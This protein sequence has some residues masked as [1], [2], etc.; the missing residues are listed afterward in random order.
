MRTFDFSACENGGVKT[1][2]ELIAE[3]QSLGRWEAIRWPTPSGMGVASYRDLHGRIGACAGYLDEEG[4]KKGD[5]A[6]I[7]AENSLEWV[8]FFW[9]CVAR[10]IHVV[11]ADFRFSP[12]LVARI[13]AD[14]G[15]RLTLDT[16]ALQALAQRKPAHD[17][18]ITSVEPDDIVE[19]VYTSG[20]TGDPKG[21][22]HRHRTICANLEPFR[23]EI[24]KYRRWARPF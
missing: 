19:I 1:L 17:F 22:V 13:R 9:A 7:W 3:I 14:S 11:P 2:I 21:I 6:I 20:T 8:G 16:Q 5:R 24:A 23:R 4:L 18:S 15:A 12:E 10:G